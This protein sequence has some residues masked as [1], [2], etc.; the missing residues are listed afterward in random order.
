MSQECS[1]KSLLQRLLPRPVQRLLWV[2]QYNSK[3]RQLRRLHRQAE[4]LERRQ[5]W[6]PVRLRKG[7]Y[8]LPGEGWVFLLLVALYLLWA[9]LPL[10]PY[11]Q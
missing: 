7:F 8:R 9:A 3:L 5:G 1:D 10:N 6:R 4:R 2:R 11:S